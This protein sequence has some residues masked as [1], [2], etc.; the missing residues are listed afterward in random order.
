[1]SILQARHRIPQHPHA[2]VR[3]LHVSVEHELFIGGHVQR[4]YGRPRCTLSVCDH[5]GSRDILQQQISGLW[6][7]V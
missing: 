5:N 2:T 6:R 1:M 4:L 3:S 7:T